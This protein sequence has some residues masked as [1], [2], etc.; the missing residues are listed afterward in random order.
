[1]RWYT[2][3]KKL[4]NKIHIRGY[5][6]GTKFCQTLNYNPVLY[7]RSKKKTKYQSIEGHYLDPIEMGSIKGMLEYVNQYSDVQGFKIYG[8]TNPIY[9]YIS[10]RYPEENIEYDISKI[11]I[12]CLDIET[13]SEYGF[14][15]PRFCN[16]EIQLITIQNYNTKETLT[17]GTK[18]FHKKLN[19]HTYYSCNDEAHLLYSF[20]DYWQNNYP[21]IIT[22]WN[23]MYFDCPYIIKRMERV[24]GEEETKKLSPFTW[25]TSRPL[26]V[27]PGNIQDVYD[28]YGISTIDYLD[29]YKKYSFKNP[30]NHRLDTIAFNELGQNKLDHSQ[31]ETF[32]D[33]YDNDWNL[34]VEYNV[35]DTQLI[36][37][38]EDKLHMIELAI[39]LAFDSK[40]NFEDVFFQVRMW[41]SIIYNY[42]KNKNI[43]IPV[44][45]SDKTKTDKYSGAYVKIPIPGSYDYVVSTDLTSLY[46]HI[47]MQHYISPDTLV[48][49]EEVND[50]IKFLTNYLK[51]EYFDDKFNSTSKIKW[52]SIDTMSSSEIRHELNLAQ[53][54]RQLSATIS[55]DKVIDK[56]EIDT[57]CLNELNVTMTPNG[58]I[59]TKDKV[60][61]LAEILNK[62]FDKRKLYKDKMKEYKKQYELT[63]DESLKKLI[64][65]YSIKEQSVK[66][67]LNSC[68]GATGNPH[69]RFYDIRNAEAV[70]YT[71][72]L[73]IKWIEKKFNDYFNRVINTD[74]FD[75]AIYM[76]TDSCFLNMKPVV[77]KIFE[78]KNPTKL[79]IVDFLD[80]LFDTSIQ[81]FLNES[82]TELSQLLSAPQNKLHMKREKICDKVV[83]MARKRYIANVWDNEGI[84]YHEPEVAMVGVE[85]IKSSTPAFCRDKLKEAIK[86][87]M[88]GTE[89]DMIKFIEK[90]KAQFFKLAPDQ[91][92]FPK[93]VNGID[94]YSC[95]RN[96]YIKGCPG[97]VKAVILYNHYVDKYKL[98]RKYSKI[99][100]GE[101]IKFVYLKEPNIIRES[102]IGFIQELPV[103]FGLHKY[104]DYETQYEKAFLSPLKSILDIVGWNTEKRISMSSFFI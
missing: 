12:V 99:K 98:D 82:Y 100:N 97:H 70:T 31:Y 33:F 80:K 101:K 62:M 86:L 40:T 103:E 17:W 26:E 91:V 15:D 81:N 2:N 28:I 42:M 56:K 90:T 11:D 51:T 35:I 78:N 50:R 92:A 104:V 76:D 43:I 1:M 48:D 22:G 75:Y 65:T 84:R 10:D 61:F 69:F 7:A 93:S 5:E 49:I 74:N 21:D 95:P 63:Q 85:A 30:E 23:I 24:I 16:E 54:L 27:R 77:D 14:P 34:F 8:N 73:A 32:K 72:Q 13:T 68:Y 66:V 39:M 89:D 64:S 47:M 55:V 38:L 45:T 96:L 4:G 19:N 29:L 88:K 9:Q 46:P 18:P 83:F 67:C 25:I 71:G 102:T 79:E 59:Y 41:D 6:K 44:K 60:G 87:I 20:L 52:K 37:R 58:S 57:E 36:S 94:K 3:V 53:R